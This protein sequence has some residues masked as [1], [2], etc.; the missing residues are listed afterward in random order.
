VLLHLVDAAGDDP[1]EAWRVVRDE[2]GAYGAALADKP[3]VA[4]L[5]R[6]DLVDAKQLAKVKKALEKA[7][8]GTAVPI[9]APTGEGIQQLWIICCISFQ[10]ICE[11]YIPFVMFSSPFNI[12]IFYILAASK[13]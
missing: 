3:E 9:S 2:L 4:A 8:G 10:M 12:K 11:S 7:I 13:I 6:S 5:S 1:V